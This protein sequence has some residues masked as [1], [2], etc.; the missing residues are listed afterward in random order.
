MTII[1]QY[2][3]QNISLNFSAFDNESEHFIPLLLHKSYTSLPFIPSTAQATD[4][5]VIQ[6]Q[7]IDTKTRCF[8]QN[9]SVSFQELSETDP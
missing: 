2:A 6:F 5:W 9:A 8:I 4:F 3:N 1:L 7:A